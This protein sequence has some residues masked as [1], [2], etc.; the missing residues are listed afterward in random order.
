MAASEGLEAAIE[1]A[2]RGDFVALL[3]GGERAAS[4]DARRRALLSLVTPDPPPSPDALLDAGAPEGLRHIALRAVLDGRRSTLAAILDAQRSTGLPEATWRCTARWLALLDE[5]AATPEP[6]APFDAE[7]GVESMVQDALF[8]LADGDVEGGLRAA[9]RASHRARAE[10]LVLHEHLSGLVLARARRHAGQPHLASRILGALDA[11]VR[12]PWRDW[13]ALESLLA[14]AASELLSGTSD[15]SLVVTGLL[16]ALA[17]RAA[18]GDRTGFDDVASAIDHAPALTAIRRELHLVRQALDVSAPLGAPLEEFARGRTDHPPGPLSGLLAPDVDPEG[19]DRGA[20]LWTHD[21]ADA[22]RRFLRVGAPL[23]GAELPSESVALRQ[24]RV[25]ELLAHVAF[26]GES[27][28]ARDAL[29]AAVYGFEYRA[30]RHSGTLRTLLHRARAA[31]PEDARLVDDDGV[32]RLDRAQRIVL[33]DPRCV[34]DIEGLVLRFLGRRAGR[35]SARDIATALGVSA[36]TVQ[37]V[38]RD[39]V[40]EGA[41]EVEGRGPSVFYRLEDTSFREPTLERLAPRGLR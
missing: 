37:N 26:A 3:E 6:S 7:S 15:A 25:Y 36:R 10:G 13:L 2:L 20:V 32:L 4:W 5:G 17:A 41:C 18:A 33:P 11:V 21:G 23:L 40:G 22:P 9:R 30:T 27:G 14:G 12:A 19:N 29:F 28:I 39:L 38:L 8:A 1:R 35:A 31:L 24:A 34:L 16:R